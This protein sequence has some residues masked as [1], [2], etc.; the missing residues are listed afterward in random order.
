MKLDHLFKKTNNINVYQ[1]VTLFLF[2]TFFASIFTGIINILLIHFFNYDLSPA[3][4]PFSNTSVFSKLLVTVLFA[5]ILETFIFQHLIISAFYSKKNL[6]FIVF[7]SALLFGLSHFYNLAYVINTF[8]TGIVLALSYI[9]WNYKKINA[10]W[11]TAIIHSLHNML[12]ILI[13]ILFLKL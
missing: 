2:L 9:L 8:F 12:V 5:P 11:G 1:F 6:K 10:F 4:R 13:E 3:T 7:I